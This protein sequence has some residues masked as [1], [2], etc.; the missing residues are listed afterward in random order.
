MRV[1]VAF[2][3]FKDSLTSPAACAITADTLRAAH[4][5]WQI[6][7]CPLTDGG[8]GFCDILTRAAGGTV[9]TISVTGP[10]GDPV[11]A[12]LG[13][14]PLAKI[15]SAAR[16][17]LA[18]PNSQPSTPNSQ[19]I[20]A[21]I[22]MATA[23][24]LALLTPDQ[25]DPWQTTTLGTG[26]LLRA[27]ARPGVVAILLGIGGSATSD[28]GLGA[29]AALGMEFR[30]SRGE[31]VHPPIPARWPEIARLAGGVPKNF[32]PLRIACDVTN[33]LLGP[34]GAAAIYGP[35]KGL[36]ADDV[37]TLDHAAARLA[38]M[39]SHQCGA[40]DSL[41]DAPGAGAAGGL[42][43]GLMAAAGARLLPGFDLVS[44]WLDLAPKLA[45][46]DL[47]I[48]GEGRFDESSLTGKGPG[49]IATQAIALG[50]RVHVFAGAVAVSPRE[51]LALHAITPPGIPLAQALREAP[52]NLAT[53]IIRA[54]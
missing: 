42:G 2:D 27:A 26:E 23:S 8:E 37:S 47:V 25:R 40:P 3:K 52:A 51:H 31:N 43:F 24:G 28:L 16:A 48:T 20:V 54:L 18:L 32:P 33:P 15:P 38:L 44:A 1:L 11:E 4:P 22:E 41:L 36:R 50:K 14:V 39:L 35:Q 21:I 6:D 29:L 49:A 46:A 13:L 53:A 34:R 12:T 17:L 7:L 10:R 9:E 19:P 30:S 5:A 45:A